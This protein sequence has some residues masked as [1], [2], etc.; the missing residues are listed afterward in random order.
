MHLW[1][2]TPKVYQ[3]VKLVGLRKSVENCDTDNEYEYDQESY[4][5][6]KYGDE[7]ENVLVS[8]WKQII[9][10]LARFESGST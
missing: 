2:W 4:N 10:L 5:E 7:D 9:W 1:D 3:H 6:A 8:Q